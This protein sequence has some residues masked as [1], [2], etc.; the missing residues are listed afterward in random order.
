MKGLIIRKHKEIEMKHSKT[1]SRLTR[2][3]AII[4]AAA[5]IAIM[6]AGC[7]GSNLGDVYVLEVDEQPEV[8]PEPEPE[9]EESVEPEEEPEPEPEQLF[10]FEGYRGYEDGETPSI[11]DFF[12]FTEDV[13][14]D[15][16]P[17]DRTAITDFDSISGYWKAYT[18]TIPM[19]E[20]EGEYLKW[21]NAEINGDANKATLIYHTKNF[22]AS[23]MET[24][25]TDDLSGM[26]GESYS[27]SFSAGQLVAGDMGTKGMEIIISEFYSLNGNQYAVGEISYKSNEKEYIVLTR[28]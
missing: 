1:T 7:G 12:W 23:D 14:W 22:F 10:N 4:L 24:G 2:L 25:R 19:F 18:E 16:L 17:A 26:D 15:G 5:L 27:G 9:P 28:P 13:K 8:A 3:W 11:G 6:S 21:F 20:G